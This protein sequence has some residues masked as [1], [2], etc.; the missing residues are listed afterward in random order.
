MQIKK[1]VIISLSIIIVGLILQILPSDITGM[2]VIKGDYY[3]AKIAVSSRIVIPEETITIKIDSPYTL[4]DGVKTNNNLGNKIYFYNNNIR[5]DEEKICLNDKCKGNY[6]IEYQIPSEGYSQS[7][8]TEGKYVVKVYDY[9]NKKY[10]EDYFTLT[11]TDDPR[12][13][14]KE[15]DN[16]DD[17]YHRGK[18][19]SF[20]TS[21]KVTKEDV[22]I[23]INRK[24]TSNLTEYW[25]CVET[26]KDYKKDIGMCSK[27][28]NCA[29]KCQD[30]ACYS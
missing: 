20:K 8:W 29:T 12:I 9:L 6:L 13:I 27:Q 28:T 25:C 15:T 7:E 1:M 2:L 18:V 23:I 19:Y 4:L 11:N 5:K 16:G 3:P 22:C 24:N 30:G 14:C 26:D 21:K 10:V 17:K